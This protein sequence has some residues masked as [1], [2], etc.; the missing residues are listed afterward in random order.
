MWKTLKRV[1]RKKRNN[2]DDDED[3]DVDDNDDDDDVMVKGW[4]KWWHDT[5]ISY[6]KY[7]ESK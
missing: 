1:K 3:D 5:E 7:I 6:K 2:N 4:F